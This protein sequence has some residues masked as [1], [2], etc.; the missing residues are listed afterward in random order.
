MTIDEVAQTGFRFT[1]GTCNIDSATGTDRDV[2][3]TALPFDIGTIPFDAI[4]RC[5]LNNQTIPVVTPVAPTVTQA[6]CVN[7]AVTPPT[8]TLPTTP[9]GIAYTASEPGPYALATPSP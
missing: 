7:G 8:L 5:T 4:V 2:V 9:P 6:Q 3:I 1:G